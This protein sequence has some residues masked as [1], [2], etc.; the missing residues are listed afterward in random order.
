MHTNTA[1][2]ILEKNKNAYEKIS[3]NFSD[4]RQTL[5]SGMDTFLQYVSDGDSVLDAGCG[6]GR[7][8]Q[9]FDTKKIE[10]IGCDNNEKLLDLARS[11]HPE[12]KFVQGDLLNLPFGNEKFDVVF[13]IAA[14]HHIPSEDY[15]KKAMKEFHRV[16]KDDGFFIMTNWNRY[17]RQFV[18]PIFK[19]T[20]LKLLGKSELDFKDIYLPWA[21]SGEFRYYHCFTLGEIKRLIQK[22]GF[23]L[24]KT[25]SEK[26]IWSK[27]KS[28]NF[29]TIC[30]KC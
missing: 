13:C 1:Q 4:S 27:K 18:K 5:W 21:N 19:Y 10:Y 24:E 17:T 28:T 15:R 25:Y 6:N 30:K 12:K 2:K 29:V 26:Q 11:R 20:I 9:L 8:V 3:Q 16:L 14:L 23:C 7:I 22:T